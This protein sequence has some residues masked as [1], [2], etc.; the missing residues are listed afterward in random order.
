MSQYLSISTTP[1]NAHINFR[2]CSVDNVRERFIG[3]SPIERKRIPLGPYWLRIEKEGFETVNHLYRGIDHYESPE[4]AKELDFVLVEKG[5]LPPGMVQISETSVEIVEQLLEP[6]TAQIPPFLIDTREV[7]NRE[8]KEFVDAG[9][10]RNSQYWEHDFVKDGRVLSFEEAVEEFQDRTNQQGPSTWEVGTF[11]EGRENF[12]VSGVSWYEAA[13]YAKFSGKHLPT[14][15]HWKA[16]TDS[17]L[18]TYIYPSSNFDNRG[19]REVGSGPPEALGTYDMAGNVKEWCSNSSEDFRF[20]L[21]GGWNEPI[22]AYTQIDFQHP[23]TR[24]DTFG[25]RC[26]KFSDENDTALENLKRSIPVRSRSR[27]TIK[28]VSDQIFEAYISQYAYDKLKLNSAV[29]S[30]DQSATYWTRE[31]V[32]F[33]ATYDDERIIAYLFLPKNVDPPYQTVIFFP[34]SGAIEQSSI[35]GQ[36]RMFDFIIK[37]GRAVMFP[38]YFG[39]LERRGGFDLNVERDSRKYSDYVINWMNELRRSLDYLQTRDEIDINRLAYYGFSWGGRLGSIALSLD[40]RLRLAVFLDGGIGVGSPRPEVMEA[41]FAPRVNV[42]VLMINGR[43]DAVFPLETRQLPLFSLLGTPDEHKRHILYESG[44]CVI[45][46]WKNQVVSDILDWLD[47]YFGR[48]V[49]TDMHE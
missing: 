10:Y 45:G 13:A 42:P 49:G 40:N 28:G 7:T 12:P 30:V 16:A 5:V 27:L 14:I 29:E 39:T 17:H 3:N 9:G 18:A 24:S 2:S 11:P 36:V 19:P 8:Y 4:I 21:G 6:E 46:F 38:I 33:D 20:V 32:T 37:S 35:D 23:F 34:G 44:H 31:R 47:D 25:F 41:N 43:N 15:Y 26:V 48:P 1:P 22:Y